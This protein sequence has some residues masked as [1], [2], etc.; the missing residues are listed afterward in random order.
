MIE[1]SVVFDVTE[2]NLMVKINMLV[3]LV[4]ELNLIK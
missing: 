4:F 3:L 1:L 2:K